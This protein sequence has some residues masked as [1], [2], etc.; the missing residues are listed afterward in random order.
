MNRLSIYITKM[1]RKSFVV[2][3]LAFVFFMNTA[4]FA[5]PRGGNFQAP[6]LD[7]MVEKIV[8]EV[9]ENSQLEQLAHELLDVV[10]PRLVGTPQMLNAHDWAVNKYKTWGIEA[11]YE[12]FGE[13]RGW[14]R[15]IS[16]I[17]MVHPRVKTLAGTQL[18]WS[19]TTGGKASSG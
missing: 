3:T 6:P 1:E 7:P 8:K 17:D 14:E 19:P 4:S 10:G 18:A 11:R 13:W 5:Q 16:H 9:N 15:G 2:L 12:A